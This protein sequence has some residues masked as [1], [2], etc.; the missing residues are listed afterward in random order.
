MFV[1]ERHKK[2]PET[3]H[4]F[5]PVHCTGSRHKST[6]DTNIKKCVRHKRDI[7]RSKSSSQVH[8]CMT[9]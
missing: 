8:A 5:F 4:T 3:T 7:N 6:A 1:C 9:I 2:S